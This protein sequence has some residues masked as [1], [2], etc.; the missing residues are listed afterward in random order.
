M[1]QQYGGDVFTGRLCADRSD[2]VSNHRHSVYDAGIFVLPDGKCSCLAHGKKTVRT[3][4]SHTGH[5]DAD[6][7]DGDILGDGMEQ[8]VYRRTVAAYLGAGTALYDVI[9]SGPDLHDRIYILLVLHGTLC[10]RSY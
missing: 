8:N 6:L 9:L 10:I 5:D 4:A 3:V 1:V 2:I 7:I